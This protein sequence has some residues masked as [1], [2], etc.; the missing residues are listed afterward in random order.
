MSEESVVAAPLLEP[1]TA[2]GPDLQSARRPASSLFPLRLTAFEDYW[3]LEDQPDYPTT[4]FIQLRMNGRADIAALHAAYDEAVQRHPFFACRVERR[5]GRKFWVW[6]PESVVPINLDPTNWE[7]TRPWNRQIDLSKENGIRVWG[8][9][10][11]SDAEITLQYHHACCDGIGA[12]QFVDDLAAGYA[13]RTSSDNASIE[14]RPLNPELLLTRS[15]PGV[16]R[17][18]HPPGSRWHRWKMMLTD[19]LQYTLH[20]KEML[21]PHGAE[22]AYDAPCDLSMLDV[23]LDKQTSR[24]LRG[25]VTRRGVTLNDLLIRDLMLTLAEWNDRTGGAHPRSRICILV[26]INLRGPQDDQLPATNVVGYTFPRR[27]RSAMA[28]PDKLLTDLS[29]EL[30]RVQRDQYSWLFVQVLTL[31]RMVP[32]LMSLSAVLLRRQCMSTAVLTHLGNRLNSVTSR[33]PTRDGR[34]LVGNTTMEHIRCF[35]VLRYGTRAGFIT[36]LLNGEL[37]VNLRCDPRVFTVAESQRLMDAFLER[38][39]RTAAEG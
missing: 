20:R 31:C 34:V 22:P 11:D 25:I 32:F 37:R 2:S 24:Q 23:S 35:P 5:W 10:T 30:G 9:V 29:E 8:R 3:L 19:S 38:L 1:S 27:T 26:P 17:V 4:S 21:R 18:A 15:D 12:S 6:A 7:Q 39:R 14:L 16:R 28:D 33:L 13:Q 36:Y